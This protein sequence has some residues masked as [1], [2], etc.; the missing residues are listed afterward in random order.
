LY[1]LKLVLNSPTTVE[2]VRPASGSVSIKFL[3]DGTLIRTY[4]V[5]TGL[6]CRIVMC[7]YYPQK[8]HQVALATR[9]EGG[10]EKEERPAELE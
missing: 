3:I 7:S 2:A 6:R 1:V 4:E 9:L 8:T 10:L 5:S